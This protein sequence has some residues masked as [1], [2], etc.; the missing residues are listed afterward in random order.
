MKDEK[1]N[2]ENTKGRKHENGNARSAQSMEI[3]Q[4]SGAFFNHE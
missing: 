4:E 1:R 3:R 2:R